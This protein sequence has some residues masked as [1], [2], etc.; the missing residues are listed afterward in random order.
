MKK[1][2]RG[3]LLNKL[4]LFTIISTIV[5]EHSVSYFNFQDTYSP[6]TLTYYVNI[7]GVS[8]NQLIQD[9]FQYSCFI[10]FNLRNERRTSGNCRVVEGSRIMDPYRAAEMVIAFL[11]EREFIKL[12]VIGE[13]S[14]WSIGALILEVWVIR[15]NNTVEYRDMRTG[16]L[17]G[18]ESN[19]KMVVRRV[20]YEIK[21]FAQLSSFEPPY[22]QN[23]LSVIQIPIE[24]TRIV[25]IIFASIIV[26]SSVYVFMKW[27][28]Y[29]IV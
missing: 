14:Y 24:E 6:I 18:V 12:N 3:I 17:V 11:M 8:T 27:S 4:F 13:K 5:F 1:L 7:N 23:N 2:L 26:L 25:L 16:L 21:L 22:Y 15:I 20:Q 28:E 9:S 19:L 10:T 29:R